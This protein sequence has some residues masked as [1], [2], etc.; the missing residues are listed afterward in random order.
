MVYLSLSE[1]NLKEMWIYENVGLDAVSFIKP[2]T[3]C[4]YD[5]DKVK[6]Y[7]SISD[8]N[9]F[10]QQFPELGNN[11]YLSIYQITIIIKIF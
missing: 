11:N 7:G 2:S 3:E 9:K 10:L 6:K 5:E 4:Y 1:F 8:W